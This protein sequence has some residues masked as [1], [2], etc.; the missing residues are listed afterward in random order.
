[1]QPSTISASIGSHP[2][3]VSRPRPSCVC[4][5]A[6]VNGTRTPIRP[7]TLSRDRQLVDRPVTEVA[8]ACGFR[9]ASTFIRLF[10]QRLGLTPGAL[11]RTERQGDRDGRQGHEGDA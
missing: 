1:M 11:R 5:V 9:D 6:S 10:R 8:E 2:S 4:S 3:T 7:P